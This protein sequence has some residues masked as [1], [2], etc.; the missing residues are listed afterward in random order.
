MQFNEDGTRIVLETEQD[1]DV[2]SEV[3]DASR[4]FHENKPR[5]LHTE[6]PLVSLPHLLGEAST[7]GLLSALERAA[8]DSDEKLQLSPEMGML[9]GDIVGRLNEQRGDK[10]DPGLLGRLAA[11]ASRINIKTLIL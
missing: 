7:R 2:A 1:L 3:V 9:A 10:R 11:G 5:P 4:Y 6:K 8:E